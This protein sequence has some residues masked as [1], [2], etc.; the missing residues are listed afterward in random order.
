MTDGATVGEVDA[1]TTCIVSPSS[2]TRLTDTLEV[3]ASGCAG[4]RISFEDL[5][6]TLAEKGHAGLIFVLAAPN[7]L[8]T[9]PGTSGVLGVPLILLS[10]QLMLGM[11]RPWLPEPVRRRGVSTKRFAVVAEKLSPLTRRAEALTARR[12]DPLTGLV[13][14]RVVGALCLCLSVVLALPIPLGNVVPAAAIS[15]LA[16]GLLAR[17]GLAVTAGSAVAAIAAAILFAVGFGAVAAVDG[18]F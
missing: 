3:L 10:L 17:D 2:D 15:L 1:G 16:L 13:G 8:P 7:M 4:E 9:P 12:L 6:A 14:R 5:T 11:R 18:L